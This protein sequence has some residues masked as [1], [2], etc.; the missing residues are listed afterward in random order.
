MWLMATYDP[1]MTALSIRDKLK[2][3]APGV[4]TLVAGCRPERMG[5]MG[6]QLRRAQYVQVAKR[7]VEILVLYYLCD[8]PSKSSLGVCSCLLIIIFVV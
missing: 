6:T 2:T 3:L 4:T 1:N 5:G 7:T 8:E